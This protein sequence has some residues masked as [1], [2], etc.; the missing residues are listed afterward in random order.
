MNSDYLKKTVWF[1]LL[2]VLFGCVQRPVARPKTDSTSSSRP[3]DQLLT[4][5]VQS[6]RSGDY[7]AAMRFFKEALVIGRGVDDGA[8]MA[9]AEVNMAETALAMGEY[10][11]AHDSLLAARRLVEREGLATL[12]PYLEMIAASLAIREERR[13]DAIA[14]LTPYLA[15]SGSPAGTNNRM[16][17]RLAALVNRI[18][19]VADDDKAQYRQWVGRY[20]QVLAGAQPSPP[21]SYQARLLRFE[22]QLAHWDGNRKDRDRS[23]S[24]ALAIL[25]QMKE[26][27]GIAATLA[28]WGRYLMEDKEWSAARDRL[29]RAFFVRVAMRDSFGCEQVLTLLES[30][31]LAAGDQQRLAETQRW[32]AV[33][34]ENQSRYWSG[35]LQMRTPAS[36]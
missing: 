10:A 34:R 23:L 1:L 31:D 27:P 25:R 17:F 24:R 29:D 11:A 6:F 33:I 7:T 36:R 26:R 32:R 19:L 20:R 8:R 15:A 14:I 13:D 28:E 2:L 18:K 5:G 4:A 16:E 12:V 35:L 30:L 9:R 22:A 3:C 21:S